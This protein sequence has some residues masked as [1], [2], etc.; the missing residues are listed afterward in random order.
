MT[1]IFSN[2]ILHHGVSIWNKEETRL[3]WKE[4]II[5][6]TYK[7]GKKLTLVIREREITATN[8][9]QILSS[10]LSRVTTYGGDVIGLHQCGFQ[11]MF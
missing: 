11:H 1:I 5:V 10:I 7:K 4:S 9:T 2:N 6:P 3:Q 8:N